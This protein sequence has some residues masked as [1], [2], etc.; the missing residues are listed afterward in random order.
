M[1]QQ[2]EE[3]ATRTCDQ[4][5]KEVAEANFDLHVSHCRRFLCLCPDCDE[6]VPRAELEKHKEEQHGE[7][8]CSKCH[9]KMERRHLTEHEEEECVERPQCCQF[10]ELDMPWK[11]LKE[12]TVVCGS[13]TEKCIDCGQYITLLN[14]KG[15]SQTCSAADNG[16][17]PPQGAYSPTVKAEVCKACKGSFPAEEI[18]KHEVNCT[19]AASECNVEESDSDSDDN[20]KVNKFD[21]LA[22]RLSSMNEDRSRLIKPSWGASWNRPRHPYE[23]GNC[24]HCNLVLPLITLRWHEGKCKVHTYLKDRAGDLSSELD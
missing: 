19:A 23:L 3:E 21:F 17:A 16:P 11:E 14:M 8:R 5:N 24:P 18:K 13:R 1:E 22:P 9:K 12:H 6:S 4:C 7:V 15:H 10:C 20:E 2:E